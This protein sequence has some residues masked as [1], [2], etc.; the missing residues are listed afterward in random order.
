[1]TADP[2]MSADQQQELTWANERVGAFMGAVKVATFNGWTVGFFAVV[3]L[4]FAFTS[5]T[6]FVMAVGLAVVAWNEFRGRT[7]VRAF[8]PDGLQL[9]GRNQLGFVVL[10]V[11]YGLWGIY[12]TMAGTTPELAELDSLMPSASELVETLTVAV[13]VGVIVL[14]LIFQGLNARYYFIRATR[15]REYLA[16]TPQWIL[17]LQRSMAKW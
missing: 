2:G 12:R 3:S 7:M 16:E 10:L 6:A 5:V 8:R 9:L 4:L 15:M 11:G 13:Y 17:D 14:S 1:M